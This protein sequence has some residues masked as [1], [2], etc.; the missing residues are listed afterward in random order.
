MM[1]TTIP[2][3]ND[4]GPAP[5]P[6]GRMLRAYLIEA[7][8][9]T[10]FVLRT[11]GMSV[12]FLAIPA[13]IYFLFGIVMFGAEAQTG[14]FGPEIANFLF[15]G[16][17]TI[18]VAMP[19]IFTASSTIPIDREGGVLKLKRA[20]P[21]PPGANFVAK[22]LATMLIAALALAGMFA[23]AIIADSTLLSAGQLVI[24][25]LVMLAGTIPFCAIGF[26]I[27]SFA[28]SSASPAYGNL[29]F[30]PMM[31]LSGIFIPLPEFLERWVVIWPAFH[32]DQLALAAAGV[33]EFTFVPA[34][35][36]AAVLAGVTVLFGGLAIRRIARSG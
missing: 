2:L 13:A 28:S 11:P 17:A 25:F 23:I 32:L 14:E 18:A 36:T 30:L 24:I 1:A 33:D 3:A 9:E 15:C 19:G 7:K 10:L 34:S 8:F 21:M 4:A 12:P 22:I 35:I 20:L 26:F 6:L 31:W 16:F 5:L 27:G 29:V